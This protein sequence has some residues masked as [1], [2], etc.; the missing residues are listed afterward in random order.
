VTGYSG[1]D[2]PDDIGEGREMCCSECGLPTAATR[3]TVTSMMIG[4]ARPPAGLRSRAAICGHFTIWL[5][6]ASGAACCRSPRTAL[7]RLGSYQGARRLTS[8]RSLARGNSMESR[9]RSFNTYGG[10]PAVPIMLCGAKECSGIGRSGVISA[11]Y[12]CGLWTP[13]SDFLKIPGGGDK[14]LE[15]ECGLSRER[16]ILQLLHWFSKTKENSNDRHA[17]FLPPPLDRPCAIVCRKDEA[18]AYA[19]YSSDHSKVALCARTSAPVCCV[20]PGG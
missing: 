20:L 4:Y 11:V 9:T 19:T 12:W 6:D 1:K 3:D 7:P 16:V 5:H 18:C 10:L 8:R 17:C 13:L 15:I 2:L 14:Y